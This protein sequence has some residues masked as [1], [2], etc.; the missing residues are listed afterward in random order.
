MK[1][2]PRPAYA[3]GDEIAVLYDPANPDLHRTKP[4]AEKVMAL[5]WSDVIVPGLT[6]V[7]SFLLAVGCIRGA[8]QGRRS[9]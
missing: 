2:N 5:E 7:L 3:V 8:W 1:L 4:V 6:L 9:A